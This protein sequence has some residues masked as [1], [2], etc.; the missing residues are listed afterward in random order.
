MQSS[1][2]KFC[3][4]TQSATIVSE[5]YWGSLVSAS[6]IL[7]SCLV[8]IVCIVCYLFIFIISYLGHLLIEEARWDKINIT[9]T[10][11]NV[12]QSEWL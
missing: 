6:L 12:S 5:Y 1:V 7:Y 10:Q 11:M 3:A 9:D 4:G 2:L 8:Y